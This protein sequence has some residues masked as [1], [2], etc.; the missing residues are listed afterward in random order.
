MP[1]LAQKKPSQGREHLVDFTRSAEIYLVIR[2]HIYFAI[3]AAA[4]ADSLLLAI[5][6]YRSLWQKTAS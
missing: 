6:K 4:I 3:L 1:A 5:N 2:D